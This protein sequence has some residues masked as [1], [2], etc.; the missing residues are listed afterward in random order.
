MKSSVS[1]RSRRSCFLRNTA[2]ISGVEF[3]WGLALPVV[4]E[5]TFL[6]LYLRSLGASGTLIGLIPS[7]FA[8]G[9]ALFCPVSAFLTSHLVRKR[10]AVV[11]SHVVSSLPFILYGFS[12]LIEGRPSSPWMFL[13]FY[14]LF[15]ALLGVVIP[16]WQ[17]YIVKIFT[18][19]KTFAALSTMF[20]LQIAARMAGGFA[21]AGAVK[22]FAFSTRGTA[23]AFI[24]TGLSFFIGSLCF[25]ITHE[26]AEDSGSAR[27]EAHSLQSLLSTARVIITDRNFVFLQLSTIEGAACITVIFFY[28]TYAVEYKGIRQAVAAGLFSVFIY[29]GGVASNVIFGMLNVLSLKGKYIAS[30]AASVTGIMILVFASGAPLFF[31]A[32]FLIGISR[33]ISQ[34]AFSPAIKAISGLDD[35]TD[36]FSIAPLFM[37]PIAFGLPW[38]AGTFIEHFSEYGQ[39]PYE[40]LFTSMAALI[41]LTTFFLCA[42]DF[43]ENR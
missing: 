20:V 25:L 6:Q 4:V 5:S 33:G 11:L 13:A 26:S 41:A 27:E 21:I 8:A 36:Y 2:G 24:F 10:R 42:V 22:L 37:L 15:S 29:A 32:S 23:L 3:F 35:A 17:N 12:I 7:I 9:M 19:D 28:A 14:A 16:V 30:K 34:L 1:E 40:I 38:G 39:V 31:A 18:P 43:K